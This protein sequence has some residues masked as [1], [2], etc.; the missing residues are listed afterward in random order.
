MGYDYETEKAG[1]FT[2]DGQRMF[3]SVRDR[4][5]KLLDASGAVTAEKMI[6]EEL[7]GSWEMMACVDRLVELKEIKELP[8]EGPWLQHR[9]FVRPSHRR[10]S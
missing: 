10:R 1:L 5:Q 6:A 7:G 8:Q 4:T 2:D 9:V 3:L